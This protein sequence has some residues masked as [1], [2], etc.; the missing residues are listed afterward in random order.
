M[1]ERVLC[2]RSRGSVFQ[3]GLPLWAI[4]RGSKDPRLL[5][6]RPTDGA[7]LVCKNICGREGYAGC[8]GNDWPCGDI[9]GAR[10]SW[11][12]FQTGLPLWA[13][14]R[15]SKDPRLLRDRPTDVAAWTEK[16]YAGFTGELVQVHADL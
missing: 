1:C 9:N 8:G 16:I 5:R 3:T 4:N 10:S 15:G 2:G 14:N 6:D 12:V 13:S 11:S 7:A